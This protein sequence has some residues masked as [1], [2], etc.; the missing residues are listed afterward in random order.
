MRLYSRFRSLL[1]ALRGP[2]AWLRREDGISLL[3]VMGFV[4]I[5]SITTS[6]IVIEVTA[7]EKSAGRDD[8]SVAVFDLAEAALNYGGD[9]TVDWA[10]TNDAD[11]T[12]SDRCLPDTSCSVYEDNNSIWTA[13][14]G[15]AYTGLPGQQ[16]KWYAKKT[17][18]VW[19][20]H[21]RATRGSTIRELALKLTRQLDPGSF[22][23]DA[24]KGVYVNNEPGYERCLKLD[25]AIVLR[26]DIYTTGGLCLSNSARIEDDTSVAGPNTT[27]YIADSVWIDSP[28]SKIGSSN[29]KIL[30]ATIGGL[31][32][33]YKLSKV[34]C[35]KPDDSKSGPGSGIYANSYVKAAPATYI[36]KPPI[37]PS[38]YSNASPGPGHPCVTQT[39]TPPRFDDNYPN[40]DTSLS[41]T[42]QPAQLFPAYPYSC[43]TSEGSISW[44]PGSPGRLTVNGTIFFDADFNPE[45]NTWVQYDGKGTI[46]FNGTIT[47]DGTDKICPTSTCTSPPDFH[48]AILV[49]VALKD[50][51]NPT[52]H[53]PTFQL[54]NSSV[55]QGAAYV[56]EGFAASQSSRFEGPVIADSFMLA[57][58][59]TFFA[60]PT[61][62]DFPGGAPGDQDSILSVEQ[63][64]WRQIK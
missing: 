1:G 6:A 52:N 54:F 5:F 4:I 28:Q 56:V 10:K 21:A 27:I 36:I 17:A 60:P 11:G 38:W 62:Y 64:S 58:T 61:D 9:Y 44:T 55:Y 63:G 23:P 34:I 14:T 25:Q 12:L 41:R 57:N 7:N 42:G 37:D 51:P 40:R 29:A 8:K 49:L 43:T 15:S 26:Q 47:F 30:K 46:Y 19:T 39:G 13:D 16:P 32:C 50:D 33:F 59:A 31:N 48:P 45:N 35:D 20:V 3:M 22:K 24:W 2:A 53:P 18:G